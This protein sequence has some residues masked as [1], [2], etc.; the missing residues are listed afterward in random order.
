MTKIDHLY[1]ALDSKLVNINHNPE[2]LQEIQLL[3]IFL[4]VPQTMP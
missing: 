1:L 2:I 3:W 4:K